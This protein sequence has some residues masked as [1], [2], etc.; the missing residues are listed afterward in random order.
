MVQRLDLPI[1]ART[2]VFTAIEWLKE[3]TELQ[4]GNNKLTSSI[5]IKMEQQD[6]KA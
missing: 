1:N 6:M 5:A 4:N 3:L 2:T